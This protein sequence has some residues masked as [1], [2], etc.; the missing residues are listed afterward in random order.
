[1]P[2]SRPHLQSLVSPLLALSER[3]GD[4]LLKIYQQDFEIIK[5]NDGSPVTRADKESHLFLKEGLKSLTPDIPVV[6]E[7]DSDSWQIDS[8]LYWLIDPLDGTRGF[9]QKNGKFCI[10]ITLMENNHPLLGLIHLPLTQE[11]FYGFEG[12]AWK[13]SKKEVLPLPPF[14]LSLRQKRLLLDGL[15]KRI[16]EQ[17]KLLKSKYSITQVDKA[18]STVPSLNFCALVSG[19]ANF[20]VR[21]APCCEWDTAA[22]QAIIEALGGK[23]V[24]LD[25][26][27]FLYG[28]PGLLNKGF[29]VFGFK[30]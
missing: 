11:T 9:I 21:T 12:A 7:E 10:N 20:Y 30:L 8:F 25:E 24:N 6:S 27:P 26:S 17:E 1:M 15:G 28:K 3:A 19:E 4:V 13:Y 2:A 14:S 18:W 16:E 23:I 22:G 29:I 5:K